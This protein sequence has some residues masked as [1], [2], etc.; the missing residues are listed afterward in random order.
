[1]DEYKDRREKIAAY[2]KKLAEEKEARA[3]II[4]SRKRIGMISTHGVVVAELVASHEALREELEA[5]R[6]AHLN[7]CAD[8]AL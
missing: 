5:E 3:K 1:M 7:S 8:H 2:N 4:M 6:E